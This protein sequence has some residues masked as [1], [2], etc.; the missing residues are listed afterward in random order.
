M[1]NRN[2]F[3]ADITQCLSLGSCADVMYAAKQFQNGFDE[4]VISI[5]LRDVLKA[6]RYLHA[7]GYIHRYCCCTCLLFVSYVTTEV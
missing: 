4:P 1:V 3:R 7:L 6:L 5:V 2:V